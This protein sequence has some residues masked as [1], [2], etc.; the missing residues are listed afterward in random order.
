VHD[1]R[2]DLWVVRGTLDH[3]VELD[4]L[5]LT[6]EGAGRLV[7]LSD[8]LDP[9]DLGIRPYLPELLGDGQAPVFLH[10]RGNPRPR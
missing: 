6:L 9:V 8:D 7:E 4:P 2:V 3:A 5:L 1:D 10:L